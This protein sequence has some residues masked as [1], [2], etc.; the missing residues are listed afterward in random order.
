[1]TNLKISDAS[2]DCG[3][4]DQGIQNLNLIDSDAWNNPGIT[5]KIYMG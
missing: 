5:K 1:M 4:D 3:I 2:W